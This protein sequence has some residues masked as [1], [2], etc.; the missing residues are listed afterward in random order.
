MNPD[1]FS[2]IYRDCLFIAEQIYNILISP[3]RT[4]RFSLSGLFWLRGD[5]SLKK[6]YIFS[7]YHFTLLKKYYI[8]IP[9]VKIKA[10][11]S[12]I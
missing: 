3:I 10:E 5:L 11:I 7:I 2:K 1:R 8:I 12:E 9:N 6:F 4:Q